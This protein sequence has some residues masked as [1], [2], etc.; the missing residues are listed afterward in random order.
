VILPDGRTAPATGFQPVGQDAAL[1]QARD[2]NVRYSRAAA[3][4]R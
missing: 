4:G 3:R 2:T 1:T